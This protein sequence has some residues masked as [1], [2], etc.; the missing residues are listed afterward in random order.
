MAFDTK[1]IFLCQNYL[2]CK[3]SIFRALLRRELSETL[4]FLRDFSGF[5][6]FSHKI[7]E[8]TPLLPHFI[9][10]IYTNMVFFR[11][12]HL[13]LIDL[14]HVF[15]FGHPMLP[16]PK[17]PVGSLS[18]RQYKSPDLNSGVLFD[19]LN[20]TTIRKRMKFTKKR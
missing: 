8:K 6:K 16:N 2:W 9:R 3:F 12:I 7:S 1:T 10:F 17:T 18:N 20:G 19:E 4:T 14:D 13:S 11:T 15:S 5:L